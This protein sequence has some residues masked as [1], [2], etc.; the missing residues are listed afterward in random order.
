MT[1]DTSGDGGFAG[2]PLPTKN[3]FSVPNAITEIIAEITNL[4][5]LKVL[6]YVIRHTWGFHEYGKPKAISID[7]FMHGRKCADGHRMD[8]GTG[9]SHHS[10]IDG[11]KRAVEHGYLLCEVNDSDL[12][13]VKKSYALKM[14]GDGEE[15]APGEESAPPEEF[16][17]GEESAPPEEFAPGEESAS[18][19]ADSSDRHAES[20]PRSKKNTQEKHSR[21]TPESDSARE[22]V[23]DDSGSSYDSP[24]PG[25]R[26]NEKEGPS[27]VAKCAHSG[28][29][30]RPAAPALPDDRRPLVEVVAANQPG[31]REHRAAS[32][33]EQRHRV[34]SDALSGHSGAPCPVLRTGKRQDQAPGQKA[35]AGRKEVAPGP[36]PGEPKGRTRAAPAGPPQMPPPDAE[37]KT[38]TCLQLFDFWRG[39][40]LLARHQL[41]RASQCAKALA[42]H[43]T[44]QQ[45]ERV[46]AYMVTEDP[47]WSERPELVDVCSVAEHIHAKLAEMERLRTV[48]KSPE[49]VARAFGPKSPAPVP[50]TFRDVSH[51]AAHLKSEDYDE[52][53]TFAGPVR[54]DLHANAN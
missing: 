54:G 18:S 48:C 3:W 52:P 30:L 11:L 40:P 26:E 20:A 2:F 41:M 29:A 13:R 34:S 51:L 15:F 31:H 4:A 16:A 36:E 39:A 7:E 23:P 5:E 42:E 37:W 22:W 33:A 19:S 10:V 28:R 14:A 44:R 21:K 6:L 46:R 43:Y 24:A 1:R 25:L 9:L 8:S 49:Q 53:A 47:W 32:P 17:P 50:T 38:R 45:V 27:H 35:G 12:A